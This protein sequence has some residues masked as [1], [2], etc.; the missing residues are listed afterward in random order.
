[1][2]EDGKVRLVSKDWPI[3]GPVSVYAARLALATKYQNKFI[4]A[5]DALISLDTKLTEAVARDRLAKAGIDVDRAVADLQTNQDAIVA[6]LKQ[7]DEQATAFGFNGTPSF[8]VGKFRIPGPITKEQFGL[9]IADARKAAAEE[10]NVSAFRQENAPAHGEGAL[11]ASASLSL[12]TCAYD[13]TCDVSLAQSCLV[14]VFSA[15][16]SFAATSQL[17]MVRRSCAIWPFATDEVDIES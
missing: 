15:S 16:H 9:A 17:T 11:T 6:K 4:E 7:I 10:V 13:F 3:L 8:I 2:K 12:M 1:M 5:H 14:R